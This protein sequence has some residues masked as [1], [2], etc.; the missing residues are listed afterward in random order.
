MQSV[1]ASAHLALSSDMTMNYRVA[2]DSRVRLQTKSSAPIHLGFAY[3]SLEWTASVG[4]IDMLIGINASDDI[5][6]RLSDL[7]CRSGIRCTAR[8][9]LD[10]GPFELDSMTIGNAKLSASLEIADDQ[11]TRVTISPDFVLALTGIESQSFSVNSISTAQFSGAQLTID[12]GGWRGDIDHMDFVFDSLTDR[13]SLF[14]SLPVT[15]NALRLRDSGAALDTEVSI[16]PGS[17][18]LSRDGSNIISPGVEGTISLRDDTATASILL[19]DDARAALAQVDASHDFLTGEGSVSVRD[20]ALHFDQRRLSDRFLKWPHAWDIVSGTLSMELE[21]NWKIGDTGTEYSGTMTHHAKSLAGNYNDIA[22]ADLSTQLT[23]SLD[24]MA[25]F[26]IS[27]TSIEVALLDVG[28]P[29]ER[30]AADFT[31]NIREQSVRVQNLSM[32]ALG[33]QIVADPFR[34]GMREEKNDMVLRPQS[35]QLQFMVDLV[36]FER[37]KLNGSISG[38]LPVTISNE[39]MTIASGRLVSDPPGGVIRY[40][41]GI[42]TED[43]EVSDSELGLVSRTLANFQFNSL[44]SDVDYTENGDLI[45]QMRLVGINPDMDEKQP[46]ILNLGVENNIPQLLR[47]LQAIRSIEEILERRSAN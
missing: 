5:P 46:I 28:L 17:V 27:P 34:F 37:I 31:L 33:G 47:S 1:P 18:A 40:L 6:V 45:L 13:E 44:T 16:S 11:T 35:I 10:T 15:L 41:P 7:E 43:A 38:V 9:S 20:A 25:G 23:A 29:L 39:T 14:A 12:D 4:Q 30:I 36:E 22:F 2:D 8:V 24:S 26:G 21:L 42:D 3:P 32:L 19:S